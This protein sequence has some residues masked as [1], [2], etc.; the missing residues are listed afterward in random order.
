MAPTTAPQL[1][2]ALKRGAVLRGHFR[3]RTCRSTSTESTA[4]MRI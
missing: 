4:E 3:A 1:R 2:K